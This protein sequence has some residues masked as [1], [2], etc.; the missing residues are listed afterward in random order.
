MKNQL[1][2]ASPQVVAAKV[3][4]SNR[5][6]RLDG[7]VDSNFAVD[8]WEQMPRPPHLEAHQVYLTMNTKE[9]RRERRKPVRA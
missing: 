8:W 4:G 2:K 9:E 3:V 6:A 7:W 5:I 1:P